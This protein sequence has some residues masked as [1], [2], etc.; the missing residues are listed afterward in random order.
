ML[1]VFLAVVLSANT[2]AA[3]VLADVELPVGSLSGCPFVHEDAFDL[4]NLIETLKQQI[5]AEMDNKH[6]C[7][8]SV[9]AIQTSL[10]SLHNFQQTI[11]P[12]VRARIAQ[13]VY[14]NALSALEARRLQLEMS[15]GTGSPEYAMLVSRIDQV[16]DSERLS[17]IE[18]LASAKETRNWNEAY[19]RNQLAQYTTNVLSAY[20]GAIRDPR[21]IGAIGGWGQALSAVMGGF[22]VAAG[23]GL[24]PVAQTIGAV[25]SAATQLITL[26]QDGDVRSAFNDLVRLKNQQTLACTYYAIKRSSCE[27][28]HA[29]QLSQNVASLREFLKN[30]YSAGE[31]GE[32]ERF[33]VNRGRIGKIA[34]VFEVIGQMGSP[35]TMDKDGVLLPYL[36]ARTVN[37]VAIGPEPAPGA[38]D[39]VIRAWLI[40]AKTNGLGFAEYAINGGTLPLAEQLQNAITEMRVK[41]SLILTAEEQIRKNLSFLDLSRKLTKDFGNVRTQVAEMLEYLRLMQASPLVAGQDKA[42]IAAGISLLTKLND[43]LGVSLPAGGL[44]TAAYEDEIIAKGFLI[45]DELAHGSIAQITR[46]SVLMLPSKG[47]DRLDWAFGVIR[48]SYLNRDVAQDL[49]TATS[50]G[51]FELGNDVLADLIGNYQAFSGPGVTFRPEQYSTAVASFSKAFGDDVIR[52]LET[53]MRGG[54]ELPELRGRTAAHLC[55]LYAPAL[56]E[57][58]GKKAS[59]ILQQCQVGYRELEFNRLVSDRMFAIDYTNGCSYVDYTRELQIQNLLADLVKP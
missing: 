52:S 39:A 54:S 10:T 30:R 31:R 32:Y 22:S 13:S 12:S 9:Q 51:A 14:A 23:L 8:Q 38:P 48:N 16:R 34:K 53:A 27:Y 55:A 43:F 2:F 33:F 59:Q 11:D 29:F 25:A 42:T 46:Q 26:L 24:N 41:R 50:F 3:P 58:G 15:G 49:P 20:L 35:L 6:G 56:K 7:K 57:M 19:Y 4:G 45:F 36:A 1:K 47:A 37:F 44:I 5:S 40:N 18:R 28:Q 21:C 17:D